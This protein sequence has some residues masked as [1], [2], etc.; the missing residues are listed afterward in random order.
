MF[1]IFKAQK[2]TRNACYLQ[3][4]RVH[5]IFASVSSCFAL[6]VHLHA[7]VLSNTSN[8]LLTLAISMHVISL[9]FS[10]TTWYIQSIETRSFV[11][12]LAKNFTCVLAVFPFWALTAANILPSKFL[13][14]HLALVIVFCTLLYLA[15]FH[16]HAESRKSTRLPSR[17]SSNKESKTNITNKEETILPK[18]LPKQ[19]KQ[20]TISTLYPLPTTLREASHI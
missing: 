13:V 14:I 1:F 2:S 6:I 9:S 15:V 12:L 18:S 7:L 11:K 17:Q 8:L 16:F 19:T 3:S 20:Q 4:L 10:N 5:N